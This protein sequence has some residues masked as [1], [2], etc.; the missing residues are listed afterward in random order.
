MLKKGED[1]T[2]TQLVQAWTNVATGGEKIQE[3]Y[4][5]YQVRGAQLNFVQ[6]QVLLSGDD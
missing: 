5:I 2:V 4:H 1:A 3:A 6:L